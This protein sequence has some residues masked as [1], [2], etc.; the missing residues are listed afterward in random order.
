MVMVKSQWGRPGEASVFP[1]TVEG[2]AGPARWLV[3]YLLFTVRV[4]KLRAVSFCTLVGTG[5]GE[6][7]AALLARS[8]APLPARAFP[9]CL[10]EELWSWA[11]GAAAFAFHFLF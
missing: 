5:V 4:K 10:A 8:V 1:P 11:E 2:E 7:A 3:C 9:T 6:E